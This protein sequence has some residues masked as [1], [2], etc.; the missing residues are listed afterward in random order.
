[1]LPWL[2]AK[3]ATMVEEGGGENKG[4]ALDSQAKTIRSPLRRLLEANFE[5]IVKKFVQNNEQVGNA[6]L[7]TFVKLLY[8]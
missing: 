6:A 3:L 1:M 4:G 5:D 8:S 2:L 7:T